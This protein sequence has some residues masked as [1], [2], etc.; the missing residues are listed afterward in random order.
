MCVLAVEQIV[1][2]QAQGGVAQGFPRHVGIDHG[3]ARQFGGIGEV[4]ITRVDIPH[5]GTGFHLV[6]DRLA[7]PEVGGAAGHIHRTVAL[8]GHDRAADRLV[9]VIVLRPED[10]G[11]GLQLPVAGQFQVEAG[12]QA[13]GRL[14]ADLQLVLRVARVGGQQLLLDDVIGRQGPLAALVPEHLLEAH[15][16]LPGGGQVEILRLRPQG[17]QAV[18]AFGA[19]GVLAVERSVFAQGEH[20]A[21]FPVVAGQALVAAGVVDLVVI[22][23]M[24]IVAAHPGHQRPALAQLRAVFGEQ[25]ELSGGRRELGL[26]GVGTFELAGLRVVQVQWRAAGQVVEA[27]VAVE[28]EA[29]TVDIHAGQRLAVEPEQAVLEGEGLAVAGLLLLVLDADIA[30]PRQG[31]RR[32]VEVV[33]LGVLP[34]AS[35]LEVIQFVAGTDGIGDLPV[36]AQAGP[37]VV[38]VQLVVAD[39]V[40]LEAQALLVAAVDQWRTEVVGG[41]LVAIVGGQGEHQVIAGLP[42]QGSAEEIAARFAT[43][44]PAVAG[45]AVDIDAIAQVVGQRAAAVQGL[46]LAVVGTIAEAHMVFDFARERF[47]REG[48]DHRAGGAFAIEDRGRAA[49]DVDPLDRPGIHRKGH[50]ARAAVQAGAVIQLHHRVLPGETTGLQ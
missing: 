48:V 13:V 29:D 27:G 15:F 38:V 5:T 8:V 18:D 33:V 47:F 7:Q 1:Q 25:R 19:G 24:H 39:V 16:R 50:G 46:L 31:L 26:V 45:Q 42:A 41:L 2:L 23:D 28:L 22:F 12:L 32:R 37:L 17:H 6:G 10:R 3:V 35:G 30:G 4:G 9:E 49:Q 20:Q 34:A 14:L 43:V 11:I 40:V 44:D 36:G 21:D